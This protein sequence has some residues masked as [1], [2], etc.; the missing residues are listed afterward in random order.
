MRGHFVTTLQAL[1]LMQIITLTEQT[2]S[3]ILEIL[4]ITKTGH[5]F[6]MTYGDSIDG[7]HLRH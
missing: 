7:F 1:A 5:I 2:V 3:N 4:S 6:Q